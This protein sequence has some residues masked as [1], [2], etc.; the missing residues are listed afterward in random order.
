MIEL[1][2]LNKISSRSRFKSKYKKF[3]NISSLKNSYVYNLANEALVTKSKITNYI[4][5]KIK[6]RR[7]TEKS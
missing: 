7:S 5:E 4:S 6:N 3:R 2:D 1:A